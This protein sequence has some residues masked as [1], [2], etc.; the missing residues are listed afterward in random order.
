MA[1]PADDSLLALA[2]DLLAEAKAARRRANV[3]VQLAARMKEA[4]ANRQSQE[5]TRNARD[6]RD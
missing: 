6:S 5:D 1:T 3:L 4:A 2:S